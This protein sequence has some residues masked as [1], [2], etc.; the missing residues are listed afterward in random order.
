MTVQRATYRGL[1]GFEVVRPFDADP[2]WEWPPVFL[3]RRYRT[4]LLRLNVEVRF[5][6]KILTRARRLSP[7]E[8]QARD[9]GL[10]ELRV[11]LDEAERDAQGCLSAILALEN[12]TCPHWSGSES[13]TCPGVT[14]AGS[15]PHR[16][17]SP[18]PSPPGPPGAAGRRP[19]RR[20][21]RV[22]RSPGRR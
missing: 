19:G 13:C 1:S 10:R 6:R 8:R 20:G 22:A 15:S 14:P 3:L 21:P 18:A 7:V 5:R 9:I 11:T 2:T 16:N 17:G 12:P 4:E